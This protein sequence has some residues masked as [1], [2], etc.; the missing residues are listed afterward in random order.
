[1][2]N[3]HVFLG[4]SYRFECLNVLCD[5][6]KNNF[7]NNYVIH[8]ICNLSSE[9]FL[10]NKEIIDFSLIDSFYHFPDKNC[11]RNNTNKKDR[12]RR[13]PLLLFVN[14]LK[15]ASELNISKFIY[16]ECDVYPVNEISYL[17]HFNLLQEEDLFAT[18]VL[19]ELKNPKIPF[20]Y[21]APGPMYFNNNHKS[22]N[23]WIKN[24]NQQGLK[25]VYDGL[26]FEGILCKTMLDANISY[27]LTGTTMAPSYEYSDNM[28]PDTMHTHQHNILNLEKTFKKF[29]ITKGKWIQKI[30]NQEELFYF[31]DQKYLKK[32]INETIKISNRKY[33]Y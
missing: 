5:L 16:Q 33:K 25:L 27:K 26:C 18:K 4:C 15:T 11:K 24:I 31:W 14:M 28:D 9:L 8:V 29:N 7:K 32:E 17:K 12:I 10:E 20:G 22:I 30:H 13:Q 19:L 21:L 1:M 6:L 23:E 3:I 2:K